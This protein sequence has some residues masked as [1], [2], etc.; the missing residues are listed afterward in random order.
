[1]PWWAWLIIFGVLVII[2]IAILSLFFPVLRVA[3]QEI[4][5]GLQVVFKGIWF[6]ICLPF[7][8]IA[9]LARRMQA[10]RERKRETSAAT[11]KRRK[12]KKTSS[13]SLGTTTNDKSNTTRKAGTGSEL[14][15]KPEVKQAKERTGNA[16]VQKREKSGKAGKR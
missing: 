10:R 8:G 11:A 4:L 12:K 7:R 6:V 1:M 15:G 13:N 16:K 5:K 14:K 3:L 2:V 9:A